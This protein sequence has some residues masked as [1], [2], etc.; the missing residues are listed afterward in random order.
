[1]W[2]YGVHVEDELMLMVSAA[3]LLQVKVKAGLHPQTWAE[4]VL[5]LL[6]G[7]DESPGATHRLS[8]EGYHF[9]PARQ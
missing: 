2:N 9:P 4:R 7:G 6:H 5:L 8:Q 1:M 3:S